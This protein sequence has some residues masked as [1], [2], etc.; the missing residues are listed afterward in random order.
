FYTPLL[1]LS[2]ASPTPPGAIA[3]LL[4]AALPEELLYRAILQTR[5]E[6]LLRDGALAVVFASVVFGFMHLP[7]NARQYGWRTAGFF[8]IGQNAF[9]GFITG[10]IY[11]RTRSLPLAVL[12][13]AW[14]GIVM[15]AAE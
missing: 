6:R 12:Q 8:C 3:Y 14:A 10:C 13:H 7:I 15:G 9:G 1:F 5:L 4:G 11:H 2:G